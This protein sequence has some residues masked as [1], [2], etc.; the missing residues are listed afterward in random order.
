MASNFKPFVP[1][2]NI[3]YQ[4]GIQL[5]RKALLHNL[6]LSEFNNRKCSRCKMLEPVLIDNL[7]DHCI[8]DI[9]LTD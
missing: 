1:R 4:L 3:S 6:T 5:N 9:F 7:C 2:T 8:K